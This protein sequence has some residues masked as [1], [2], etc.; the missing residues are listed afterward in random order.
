M[1]V[2]TD[3]IHQGGYTFAC[4]HLICSLSVGLSAGLGKTVELISMKLGLRMGFAP[5]QTSLT[6]S[7]DPDN[8][9]DQ[10][11]FFPL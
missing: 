6:F 5:E 10:I 4:A 1:Y 9:T 3:N 7:A 8:G 2:D 11:I